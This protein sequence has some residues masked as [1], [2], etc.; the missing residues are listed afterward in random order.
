M[1]GQLHR[2]VSGAQLRRGR[3]RLQMSHDRHGKVERIRN[4][5]Q[6]DQNVLVGPQS[7][8]QEQFLSAPA[9]REWPAPRARPLP[10]SNRMGKHSI[11]SGLSFEFF[12]HALQQSATIAREQRTKRPQACN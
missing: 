7:I 10:P 8:R 2:V 9:I 4:L 12:A 1:L 5:V 3:N 6:P 11:R